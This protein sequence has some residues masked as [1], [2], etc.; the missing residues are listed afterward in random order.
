[1]W[2]GRQYYP[3]P[4]HFIN[5]AERLGVCKRISFIP[6]DAIPHKTKLFLIHAIGRKIKIAKN[7]NKLHACFHCESEF[8]SKEFLYKINDDKFL[9]SLC[10]NEFRKTKYYPAI[11]GFAILDRYE[12]IVEDTDLKKFKKE[13]KDKNIKPISI[14]QTKRE[15][16]RG[17]GYRSHVGAIYFV[18]SKDLDEIEKIVEKLNLKRN[19]EIRGGFVKFKKFIPINLPF[20]RGIKKFNSEEIGIKRRKLPKKVRKWDKEITF[21]YSLRQK[22]ANEKNL[23]N[24]LNF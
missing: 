23:I 24:L 8:L 22:K 1:M 21:I 9:C 15:E 14:S 17:C 20:F 7:D 4:E 18:S 12:V 3:T 11:I 5:E 13:I 16:R 19:I 6:K 10:M 2:V